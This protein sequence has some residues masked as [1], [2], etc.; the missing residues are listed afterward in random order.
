MDRNMWTVSAFN[1]GSMIEAYKAVY[2]LTGHQLEILIS[3]LA[4]IFYEE[5]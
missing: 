4:N 1:F 3:L 2:G 5:Q